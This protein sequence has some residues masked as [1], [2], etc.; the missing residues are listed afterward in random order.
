MQIPVTWELPDEIKRRFGQRG[1]GRQRAMV[2][3]GHLLLVLHKLPDRDDWGRKALYFWRKPD[4]EWACS[5][6]ADGLRCL[7]KHIEAYSVAEEDFSVAFEEAESAEHYFRILQEMA[8][9]HHAAKNLHATMQAAREGVPDDR[10][11]IDLRDWTY[12]VERNLDL[13]HAEAKNALDYH[14]AKKSEEQAALSM[15]SIRIADRLN[16]LAAIF[17]PLT[18][19]ASLFGMSLHSG[20]ES[21]RGVFWFVLVVGILL[22]IMTRQWVLKE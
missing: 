4:G 14:I 8:P 17:F 13:L 9:V 1:A 3:E 10:D 21:V 15:Q 12:D 16:I 7:R 5:E 6:K 20:F 2:A 19:I 11:I 22:G 18:A